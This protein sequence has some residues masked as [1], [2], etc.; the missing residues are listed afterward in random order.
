MLSSTVAR[1]LVALAAILITQASAL[2]RGVR[3]QQSEDSTVFLEASLGLVPRIEGA[4]EVRVSVYGP[5][6]LSL[7]VQ[8][9]SDSDEVVSVMRKLD[10]RGTSA[11]IA[12]VA[13]IR[14]A[15]VSLFAQ[16][17]IG[18]HFFS[19]DLETTVAGGRYGVRYAFA[20]PFG[21]TVALRHHR[22][23]TFRYPSPFPEAESLLYEARWLHSGQVGFFLLVS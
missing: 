16:A 12:A 22:L 11:T 14:R 18:R 21:V 17:E 7:A 13:S 3:A 6:S 19:D 20:R 1:A 5:V 10:H 2:D 23:S 4:A 9:W 15:G 8:R